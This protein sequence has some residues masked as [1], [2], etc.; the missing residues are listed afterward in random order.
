MK[1]SD[2]PEFN[3]VNICLWC[4]QIAAVIWV[5]GHGQCTNCG[6]NI[7]EC[8]RGE[9]CENRDNVINNNRDCN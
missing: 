8:C 1:K 7:D 6:Y 4:G 9:N 5:H 2:N 3:N